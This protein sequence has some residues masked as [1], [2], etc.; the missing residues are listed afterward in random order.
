M[1]TDNDDDDDDCTVM[2]L[3]N[4]LLYNSIHFRSILQLTYPETNTDEEVRSRTKQI[5]GLKTALRTSTHSFVIRFMELDGLPALLDFLG[6]LDYFTAQSSIHTSIIGCV[7]ALMNNS[8]MIP[9]L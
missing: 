7:K 1:T 4:Y 8:V 5:D 3:I 9:Y 2:N 6:R